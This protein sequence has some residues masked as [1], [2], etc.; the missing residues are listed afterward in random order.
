V[1]SPLYTM[2]GMA[3]FVGTMDFIE[4]FFVL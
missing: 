4:A 2:K 1:Q 3:N